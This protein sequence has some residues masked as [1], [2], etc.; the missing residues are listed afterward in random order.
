MFFEIYSKFAFF[1]CNSLIYKYYYRNFVYIFIF[2]RGC[3]YN[4]SNKDNGIVAVAPNF[5]APPCILITYKSVDY[6][7]IFSVQSLC[8]VFCRV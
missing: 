3:I 5:V 7:N 2:M 1:L 8:G 6:I 4:A